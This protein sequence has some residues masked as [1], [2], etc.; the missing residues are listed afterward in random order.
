MATTLPLAETSPTNTSRITPDGAVDTYRVGRSLRKKGFDID[1]LESALPEIEESINRQLAAWVRQVSQTAPAPHPASVANQTPPLAQTISSTGIQ[2]V[3]FETPLPPP[4]GEQQAPV[5]EADAA[6]PAPMIRVGPGLPPDR[7]APQRG[8]VPTAF[9]PKD[10][11]DPEI[12]NRR[13]HANP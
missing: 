7:E 2:R 11:F 4:M 13:F 8:A 10:P 6:S 3:N 9:Q 1:G 12:F 5:M